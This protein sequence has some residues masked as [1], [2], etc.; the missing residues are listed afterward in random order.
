MAGAFSNA[1]RVHVGNELLVGLDPAEFAFP[2]YL[3]LFTTD[4]GD[5][6]D[7]SGEPTAAEYARQVIAFASPAPG[8]Y[9]WANSGVVAFA[10]AVSAWG[11]LAWAAIVDGT[12]PTAKEVVHGAL[13]APVSIPAGYQVKLLVGGA[14]VTF[15]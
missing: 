12:G 7:Y 5:G 13:G 2:V 15:P 4:P 8:V 3:A 14:Q 9:T 6:G 11:N 10:T 1:A